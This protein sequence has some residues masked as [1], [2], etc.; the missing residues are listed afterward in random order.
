LISATGH[1]LVIGLIMLNDNNSGFKAMNPTMY[2]VE[3]KSMPFIKDNPNPTFLEKKSSVTNMDIAGKQTRKSNESSPSLKQGE[4]G[5][6]TATPNIVEMENFP[7]EYYL[8]IL[9]IKLKQNWSPPPRKN[10]N[11]QSTRCQINFQIT[12]NGQLQNINLIQLSGNDLYDQVALR[13]V[14][15][16]NNMPPLPDAFTE[17]R[18][19]V[20][21]EF[22][23]LK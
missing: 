18:L 19:T 8:Q 1:F 5:Y 14:K 3:L 21:V 6:S 7:F 22:E 2:R 16:I 17:D 11:P 12:R 13:A 9:N 4:Q 15:Q 23:A 10:D 20:T